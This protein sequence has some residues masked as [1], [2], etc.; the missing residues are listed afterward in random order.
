MQGL[1]RP[2]ATRQIVQGSGGPRRKAVREIADGLDYLRQEIGASDAGSISQ[3]IV[4]GRAD[5]GFGVGKTPI[6]FIGHDTDPQPF[7]QK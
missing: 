4:D 3:Q 1:F 2:L 6:K 7:K 5:L